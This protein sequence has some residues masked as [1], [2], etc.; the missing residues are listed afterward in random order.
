[1]KKL[2]LTLVLSLLS[3]IAF[4]QDECKICGHYGNIKLDP[5]LNKAEFIQ[6]E[7]KDGVL[8][9]QY[10]Q[11]KQDGTDDWV[12]DLEDLKINEE[13]GMIHFK[14]LAETFDGDFFIKDGKYRMIL[15]S[16]RDVDRIMH[17]VQ[18]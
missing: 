9:A 8:T 12:F 6:I 2:Y 7:M 10:H 16:D 1:M 4:S 5:N 14:M 13:D 3:V 11:A 15:Y 17:M 18:N